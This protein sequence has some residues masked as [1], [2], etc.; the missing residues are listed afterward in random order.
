MDGPE[1]RGRCDD[2]HVKDNETPDRRSR[3]PLADH[4]A[5]FKSWHVQSS[6]WRE[7]Y[8]RMVAALAAA[9]VIYIVAA[10]SGVVTTTPLAVLGVMLVGVTTPYLLYAWADMLVHW[11]DLRLSRDWSLSPPRDEG[12]ARMRRVYTRAL[13]A[14]L[15]WLV[16]LILMSTLLFRR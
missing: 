13:P 12:E 16:G 5:T 14:E 10:V 3:N 9:G 1:R 7:V 15:L 8:V 4:L 11:R 2:D 6:F